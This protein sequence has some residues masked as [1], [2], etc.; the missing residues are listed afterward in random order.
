MNEKSKSSQRTRS[1]GFAVLVGAVV[2]V[3]AALVLVKAFLI[4]TYRIPQNGM[5]PGLPS[6]SFLF[7]L[8]KPYD[9]PANVRRGDIVIFLRDEKTGSYTYI[10]RV[11]GLPG[12]TVETSGWGL[13]V[14]G[15]VVQRRRVGE[16]DGK[17]IFH[18]RIGDAS[19][20]IALSES[21][22]HEPPDVSITVPAGH[23]FV[24][25]DNRLEAMDSRY[26]GA[27]PFESIVGKKL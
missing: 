2:V 12:E 7:A 6:G 13:K 27:I 24:M 20:E 21:P 4:G 25:G 22:A 10:W 1:I 17:S 11:V 14:N 16:R 18:E 5:Y 15:H 23:F 26:F 8:K 19:Y 3:V 9:H